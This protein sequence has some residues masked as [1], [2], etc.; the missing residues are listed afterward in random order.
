MITFERQTQLMGYAAKKYVTLEEYFLLEESS[1][2]EKYEYFEG[3]ITAMAGN[4]EQHNRIL[5]NLLRETGAFLKGKGCDVFPSD[6]RVTTPA[7]RNYFYPD[8]TIVCGDAEKQDGVFDTLMNPVVIVEVISESTENH[9]RGYKFF[10]YQQ[11]PTLQEYVL[12]DS[13]EYA[14]E[15][16]RRQDDGLWKFDKYQPSDKVFALNSINCQLSFEDIYYRVRF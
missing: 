5:I 2:A 13:R 9:D 15:I 14:I 12:I 6:F 1:E 7:K 3:D 11:I 10:A 8:A 16:I 4:T